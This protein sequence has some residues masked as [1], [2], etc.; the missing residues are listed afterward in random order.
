MTIA[1]AQAYFNTRLLTDKWDSAT[2]NEKE[3]ALAQAGRD[4]NSLPLSNPTT[5]IRNNA[6]CEQALFLLSLTAAD[7]ERYRAHAM[8][9]TY[10]QVEREREDYRGKLS[11]I[12]PQA[13]ALLEGYITRH[14]RMGGIR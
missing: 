2:N 4:I 8:G 13:L 3:R 6:I 9:I 11:F 5:E 14:R 7:M 10:R 12:A 1:Q